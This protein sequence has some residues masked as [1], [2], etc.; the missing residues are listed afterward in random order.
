MDPTAR[1]DGA[2]SVTVPP[3]ALARPLGTDADPLE[4]D[5]LPLVLPLEWL[6]G[7][8]PALPVVGLDVV[9]LDVDVEPLGCPLDVD[10]AWVARSAKYTAPAPAARAVTTTAPVVSQS[11]ATRAPP[12]LRIRPNQPRI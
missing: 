1:L 7:P 3:D 8:G 2:C 11:R 4:G 10:P 5:W 12:G 6:L 9:A